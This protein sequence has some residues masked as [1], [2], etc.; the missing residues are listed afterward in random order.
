[1][2]MH[3]KGWGVPNTEVYKVQ[4]SS[5]IYY[6]ICYISRNTGWLHVDSCSP[7]LNVKAY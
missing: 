1:M 3:D 6:I 5:I 2:I 7:P 4:S